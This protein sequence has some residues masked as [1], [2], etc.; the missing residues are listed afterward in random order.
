MR[1][2]ERGIRNLEVAA[3]T[4]QTLPNFLNSS[5]FIPHCMAWLRAKSILN[6][7]FG[8]PFLPDPQT[9][10][11]F[12]PPPAATQGTPKEALSEE[13]PTVLARHFPGWIFARRTGT[14]RAIADYWLVRIGKATAA[15]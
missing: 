6:A 4:R 2:E 5:F 7:H 10:P 14:E 15:M 9:F 13:R 3:D 8:Q 12:R 11:Y 1:N